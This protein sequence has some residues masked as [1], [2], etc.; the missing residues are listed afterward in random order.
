MELLKFLQ[1]WED[2]DKNDRAES[3]TQ[4]MIWALQAV[5]VPDMYYKLY[6][7]EQN[8]VEAFDDNMVFFPTSEEDFTQMLEMMDI[9]PDTVFGQKS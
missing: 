4:S 7:P 9:N 1:T 2:Q 8:A 5:H 6:A 3:D